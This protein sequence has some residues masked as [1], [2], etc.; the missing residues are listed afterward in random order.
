MCA[1][2]NNSL[3][4]FIHKFL[5]Q[6]CTCQNRHTWS[7]GRGHLLLRVRRQEIA[8]LTTRTAV[9]IATDLVQHGAV[10]LSFAHYFDVV[11]AVLARH[12]FQFFFYADDGRRSVF[13][14]QINRSEIAVRF[15]QFSR[16]LAVLF[17]HDGELLFC[18]LF[19]LFKVT[20]R[21]PR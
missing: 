13:E 5:H 9:A 20:T 14:S 17:V 1:S 7:P 16:T 18:D 2:L 4:S 10:L 8:P 11:L 12:N 6:I 15:G 3:E 19:R 21:A